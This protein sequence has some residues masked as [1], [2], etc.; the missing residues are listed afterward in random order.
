ML[1]NY[2]PGVSDNT[3]GA[4]WTEESIPEEDFEVTCSQTLSKTVTVTTDNYIP[5]ASGVDYEPDDE[6]GYYASGW[7]D[8][9]DTSETDWAKEYHDCDYHTPSQLLL[10]F[11]DCLLQMRKNGEVFRTLY[12]TNKLIEE[13]EGWTEDETEYIEE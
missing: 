6:G 8:D 1:S 5:G 10:L 9:P 7:H 2:P 3:P 4:P 12:L 11:K 13:C